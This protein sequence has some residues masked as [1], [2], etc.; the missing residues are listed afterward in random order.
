MIE[1]QPSYDAR[2]KA[3]YASLLLDGLALASWATVTLYP[4]TIDYWHLVMRLLK[5]YN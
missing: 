4:S 2:V 5:A 3:I 1:A